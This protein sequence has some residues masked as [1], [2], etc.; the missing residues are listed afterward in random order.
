MRNARPDRTHWNDRAPVIDPTKNVLD[1]VEAKG[2]AAAE[3][4]EADLRYHEG[5]RAADARFNEAM[6]AA[7][8]RRI[9]DLLA[10][11]SEFDGRQTE[12][13]RLQVIENSK[14]S[15]A[16][17]VDA[18]ALIIP[19]VSELERKSY[20]SAGKGMGSRDVMAYVISV[21]MA[22]IAVAVAV[23]KH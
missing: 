16:Q 22:A 19:R 7:A 6:L 11:K 1:L 13:L 10:Q 8:V 15:S 23:F 12:V 21:V 18:L 14:Q 17:L 4:R 20:E 3:L 2:R 9:D 5:M